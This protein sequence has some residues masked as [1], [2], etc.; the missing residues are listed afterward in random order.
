MVRKLTARYSGKAFIPQGPCDLPEGSVVDLI[1]D[2]PVLSPPTITDKAA[3]STVLRRI[4]DRMR[5]NPINGAA[6]D[7]EC[8]P[9]AQGH[10]D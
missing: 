4:V 9:A 3:R 7:T 8:Q 5:A 6:L 10:D 1:I 2:S